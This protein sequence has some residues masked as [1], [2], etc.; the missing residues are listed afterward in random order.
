VEPTQSLLE[1][2]KQIEVEAEIPAD[3]QKMSMKGKDLLDDSKSAADHRITSGAVLDLEPKVIRVEVQTPDNDTHFV[4]LKPS[5]QVEEIKQK[6]S[7]KTGIVPERQVVKHRGFLVPE[8]KSVVEM[9]IR[10]GA[11]LNVE[12]LKVPLRINIPDGR[13]IK[14]MF[15]LFEPLSLLKE[16]LVGES[17]VPVKKQMISMD[18]GDEFVGDSKAV[19]F[20]GVRS[21]SI[22]D[23]EERD[24][25]IVF[26]DV[27][28]GT[29]FGLDR[30][31]A[32]ATGVITPNQGSHF[33]FVEATTANLNAEKEKMARAMLESPNLGVK[34]QVV[35]E[36]TD[37]EDYD[38]QEAEAVKNKWG[39]S[40]KKTQKSQRGTEFI[41]VDVRTEGVGYLDRKKLMDMKFIKPIG[42]G[43]NETLEQAEKDQQ[44]YDFY[45][46]EIRRIFRISSAK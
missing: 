3:N 22:L 26:V 11:V 39:V 25:P 28:Y 32:I 12:I 21:G 6:I 34:P 9:G 27:L 2:K 31:E 42:L 41:F 40:L 4:D 30:E 38:V 7:E 33:E 23:L 20:F 35:V 46:R 18:E 45:V 10:E 16:L 14:M 17:K 5:D 1:I 8:K 19:Y 44:R 15:D 24:D 29:L 36:K 13:Q 37:V 43:K